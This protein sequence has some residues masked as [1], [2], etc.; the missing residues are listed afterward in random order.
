MV[1]TR[2]KHT[3]AVLPMLLVSSLPPL[4]QCAPAAFS[5]AVVPSW[6]QTLPTTMFSSVGLIGSAS[7]GSVSFAAA[8]WLD[9]PK[10]VEVITAGGSNKSTAVSWAYQ[11]PQL[12]G[13]QSQ[14]HRRPYA[15]HQSRKKKKKKKKT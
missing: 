4:L 11:P 7:S 1:V 6:G 2:H 9:D 5:A 12:A 15:G 8:T 10:L 13:T 14:L 3:S